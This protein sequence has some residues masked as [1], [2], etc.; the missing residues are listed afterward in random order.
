MDTVDAVDTVDT[1]DTVLSKAGND[2]LF[3]VNAVFGGRNTPGFRPY[4]VV[5]FGLLAPQVIARGSSVSYSSIR[6]PLPGRSLIPRG[7]NFIR[8]KCWPT[9]PSRQI[10]RKLFDY[11]CLIASRRLREVPRAVHLWDSLPETAAFWHA[12]G[13]PLLL[14]LQMAHPRCYQPLIEAGA[15]DPAMLGSLE[16]PDTDRCITLAD[17]LVCPSR[18]VQ[19]SLPQEVH[20]KAV[21][22]P[23]GAD[24]VTEAPNPETNQPLRV[25]RVLFAGNVNV[26]KGIPF[27]LEAWRQ[28]P[29]EQ[30][31]C[32]ELVICGRQFREMQETVEAAPAG[33]RWVGFQSD[34]APWFKAADLFVLPSL[35]EGSAKAVYEAMAYG[36]PVVVSSH[37]GSVVEHGVDGWVVPPADALALSQ[38]I[39]ALLGDAGLRRRLGEAGR[40]TV[41]R[42]T[43]DAYATAVA[44]LYP[45]RGDRVRC[46]HTYR[47]HHAPQPLRWKVHQA[48]QRVM[49]RWKARGRSIGGTESSWL[50]F[51]FYHHVFADERRGFARHLEA[52]RQVGEFISLDQALELITGGQP[53][54]GRYFCLTF[55]DGLRNVMTNAVPLLIERGITATVFVVS[56]LVTQSLGQWNVEQGRFFGARRQPAA[57]LSWEDCKTLLESGF[58]IGS[59]SASHRRFV[60]LSADEA[61]HELVASKKRIEQVLGQPCNHFC[62]PWGK[63]DR[64][65]KQDRDPVL[66]ER[67]GYRSFL[68]TRWGSVAV[69]DSPFAIRRVGLVA[70]YGSA[71]LRYFLSL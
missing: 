51:P 35:M 60:T 41:G 56:D 47:A 65:F 36:L 46:A 54:D 53:Y 3:I 42:Y 33:I 5:R 50:R 62:C 25:L 27:L 52:M 1:V 61:E 8:I 57:F 39:T 11:L 16:D 67:V 43:W 14:D 44:G 13:V 30:R 29:A 71:Q 59:H 4:Q 12:Q 66:A 68:T 32:A 2:L 17:R 69:G 28:L 6:F 15:V 24:P 20:K 63:P 49:I 40:A 31:D 58:S 21:V 9:L 37:T 26:R 48:A 70:K 38:A 23:F 10:E 34:M 55:D 7:L 22:I 19:D 45:E 18:F 64:D